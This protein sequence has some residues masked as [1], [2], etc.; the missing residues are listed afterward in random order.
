MR[1]QNVQIITWTVMITI[2]EFEVTII[3]SYIYL[4]ECCNADTL[5]QKNCHQSTIIFIS[6]MQYY[7]HLFLKYYKIICVHVYSQC[8]R[9]TVA[10]TNHQNFPNLF[11]EFLENLYNPRFF[12]L[13]DEIPHARAQFLRIQFVVVRNIKCQLLY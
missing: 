3:L 13:L 12:F 8:F 9:G 7:S 6:S 1:L 2:Q 11:F 10:P 5:T 4:V